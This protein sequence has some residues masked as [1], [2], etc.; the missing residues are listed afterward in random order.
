M[1]GDGFVLFYFTYVASSALAVLLKALF[2][3][4]PTR[5]T[6]AMITIAISATII[7]YSTAV[8]PS[9]SLKNLINLPL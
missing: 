4:L 6:I 5:I 2:A 1:M 7:A 3:L 8:A 9:S